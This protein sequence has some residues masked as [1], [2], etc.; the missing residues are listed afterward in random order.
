MISRRTILQGAVAA[1]SLPILALPILAS[2]AWQRTPKQGEPNVA[3]DH[4]SLYKV[5][6]DQRFA[7]ARAFGREAQ[8]RRQAVRAFNG[9]VTD[10][11]YHDLYHRWKEGRAAIAG[12]T[13]YG[14]LFCLQ[15]LA[16][17]ARM[18]VIHRVEHRYPEQETLY[19]WIIA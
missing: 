5:L 16:R 8:W 19:S 13:T 9:D 1:T 17:D 6:V 4:P 2:V 18:R 10:V 15:E 7:P 12:F 11:W 14:A 3:L